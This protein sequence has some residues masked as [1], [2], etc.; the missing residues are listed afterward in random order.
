MTVDYII[1]SL[2]VSFHPLLV[3]YEKEEDRKYLNMR[4]TRPL[5]A[6]NST[7]ALYMIL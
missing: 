4:R 5:R 6:V 7:T 3:E 2:H 1:P